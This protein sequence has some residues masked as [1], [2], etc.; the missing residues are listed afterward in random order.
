MIICDLFYTVWEDFKGHL[1]KL[2]VCLMVI[3]GVFFLPGRSSDKISIQQP[4]L[5]E[6]NPV[7]ERHGGQLLQGQV[8]LKLEFLLFHEEGHCFSV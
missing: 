2:C 1:K 8:S 3:N 5:A 7:D 4:Q 6:Q